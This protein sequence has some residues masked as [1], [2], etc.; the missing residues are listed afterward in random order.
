MACGDAVGLA[1]APGEAVA[2]RAAMRAAA[3]D[4]VDFSFGSSAAESGVRINSARPAG[5]R[6]AAER[7][8]YSDIM[9]NGGCRPLNMGK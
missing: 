6:T 2:E 1:V 9:A 3:F 7:S 4:V 8:G 5:A